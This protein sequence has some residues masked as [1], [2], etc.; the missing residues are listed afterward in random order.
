MIHKSFG[1][2]RYKLATIK[3]LDIAKLP[4]N[5]ILE[6]CEKLD[7]FNVNDFGND[8]YYQLNQTN[9][10]TTPYSEGGEKRH[11]SKIR[12]GCVIFMY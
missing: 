11:L 5:L 1:E 9:F 2:L 10:S 3:D 6:H 4:Q 7:N 8:I 12:Y